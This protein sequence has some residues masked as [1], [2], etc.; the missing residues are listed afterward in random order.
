[1]PKF[2]N[3]QITTTI[4]SN[5]TDELESYF[6]EIAKY[7]LLSEKEEAALFAAMKDG[8]K[9]A[10]EKI[11]NANLRFVVSIAK[12]YQNLGLDL[13][14]LINE[15]NLGLINAVNTFDNTRGFKF[16][17]F[18]VAEIRKAI[19]MALTENSRL[20]RLPSN[21][22]GKAVSSS[23]SM[24]TPIDDDNENKTYLD[25]FA[26]ENRT[27][28]GTDDM[29]NKAILSA[30]LNKLSPKDKQIICAIFGV[31]CREHTEYEVSLMFHCTK[32]RIRQK[33]FEILETLRQMA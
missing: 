28:A 26:S 14:D 4:T 12:R 29:D 3:I 31:G 11:I 17:S 25:T 24:D 16:I 18:A 32:E 7:N 27:D 23:F 33:K 15:G 2:R 19:C 30:L 20:V 21:M 8:D 10:K 6:K 22:V 1:M 5:R 9:K 13:L